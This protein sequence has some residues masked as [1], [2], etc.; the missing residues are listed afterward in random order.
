VLVTVAGIWSNLRYTPT[1][2][3]GSIMTQTRAGMTQTCVARFLQLWA[4]CQ[5][6]KNFNAQQAPQFNAQEAPQE[7]N[8]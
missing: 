3:F 7:K 6:R 2:P 5:E 1:E 4:A 8:L